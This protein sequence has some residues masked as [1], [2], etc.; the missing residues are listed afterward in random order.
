[1][2]YQKLIYNGWIRICDFCDYEIMGNG[3]K[4]II[5]NKNKDQIVTSYIVTHNF[6][7]KK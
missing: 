5:F 1:M 6:L 7:H 2:N 4:R 3:E